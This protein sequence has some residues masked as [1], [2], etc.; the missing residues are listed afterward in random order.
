MNHLDP[1]RPMESLIQLGFTVE[2]DDDYQLRVKPARSIDE[3]VHTFLVANKRFIVMQLAGLEI[4]CSECGRQVA[5]IRKPDVSTSGDA[6]M[7]FMASCK[8][9][10]EVYTCERDYWHWRAR[11]RVQRRRLAA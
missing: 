11:N 10:H 3:S 4:P 8:C 6:G 1:T 9:G 7:W 2:L 5:M